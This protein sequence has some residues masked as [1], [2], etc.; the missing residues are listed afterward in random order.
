[1]GYGICGKW[2]EILKVIIHWHVIEVADVQLLL[3]T[4]QVCGRH[5]YPWDGCGGW[6]LCCNGLD[7][8]QTVKAEH[9]ARL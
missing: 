8:V 4:T 3:L 9:C 6:Y 7:K 5:K 2:I 1:M